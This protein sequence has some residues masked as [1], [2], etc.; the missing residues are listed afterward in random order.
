M[1]EHPGIMELVNISWTV[2]HEEEQRRGAG[3]NLRT[4]KV[5]IR[6]ALRAG[7]VGRECTLFLYKIGGITDSH[8]LIDSEQVHRNGKTINIARIS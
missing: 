1:S 2:A 5:Y 8:G 7:E 4:W 3:W 6:G